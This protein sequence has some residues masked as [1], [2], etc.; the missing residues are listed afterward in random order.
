MKVQRIKE[1][2]KRNWKMSPEHKEKIS[3]AATKNFLTNHPF[4]NPKSLQKNIEARKGKI[5]SPK[6]LFKKGNQYGKLKKGIKHTDEAKLKMSI[7]RIGVDNNPEWWKKELSERVKKNNPMKNPEIARK[8]VEARRKNIEEKNKQKMKENYEKFRQNAY[9]N[10][11]IQK[12]WFKSKVEITPELIKNIQE[13]YLSG[14][15]ITFLSIKYNLYIG[16]IRKILLKQKIQI[17]KG[18]VK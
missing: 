10:P 7:K 3:F 14:R 13:D 11:N 2:K 18:G 8:N 15:S 12:N 4:K 9:S 5:V 16:T 6:T 1:A 17:R